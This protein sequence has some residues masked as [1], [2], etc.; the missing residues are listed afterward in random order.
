MTAQSNYT[1]GATILK[2]SNLEHFN[3]YIY[4]LL[5]DSFV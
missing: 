4:F 1:Q 3:I 2:L 5:A